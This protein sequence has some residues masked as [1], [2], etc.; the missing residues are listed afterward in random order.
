M[1]LNEICYHRIFGFVQIIFLMHNFLKEES[2]L[3]DCFEIENKIQLNRDA[4]INIDNTIKTE[5]KYPNSSSDGTISGHISDLRGFKSGLW[6]LYIKKCLDVFYPK[7][8]KE[9]SSKI[10]DSI[11]WYDQTFEWP[12]K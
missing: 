12:R 5:K 10:L 4:I 3:P 8:I 1:W 7:K 6:D 9:V 2:T 11:F